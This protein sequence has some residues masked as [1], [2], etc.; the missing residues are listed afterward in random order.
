MIRIPQCT[1]LNSPDPR[2]HRATQKKRVRIMTLAIEDFCASPQLLLAHEKYKFT[3]VHR[4]R[5]LNIQLKWKHCK[6]TTRN[7]RVSSNARQP[8][9]TPIQDSQL[10]IRS[11]Q[12]T[13]STI[14][15]MELSRQLFR[16]QCKIY[17]SWCAVCRSQNTASISL[18]SQSCNLPSFETRC[19]DSTVNCPSFTVHSLLFICT[20][21]V[22][23]SRFTLCPAQRNLYIV[24]LR[25]F[26][27]RS[28]HFW[29]RQTREPIDLHRKSGF[30]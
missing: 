21:V 30:A 15:S 24:L 16:P 27:F 10:T 28:L 6:L 8:F 9:S 11:L 29:I 25:W 5:F 13:R 12:L 3:A 14:I 1:L 18:R 23:T 19:A 7:K 22:H 2:A 4:D 20:V 26:A 17:T